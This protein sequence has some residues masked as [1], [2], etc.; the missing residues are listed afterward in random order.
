MASRKSAPVEAS[1]SRSH[2]CRSSCSVMGYFHFLNSYHLLLG[3]SCFICMS[4]SFRSQSFEEEE[5]EGDEN[6]PSSAPLVRGKKK[7]ETTSQSA[8]KPKKRK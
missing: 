4:I 5:D 6:V 3:I 2:L 1:T 8:S 7:Q